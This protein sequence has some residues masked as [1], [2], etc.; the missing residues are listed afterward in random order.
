M[1]RRKFRRLF[2]EVSIELYV[3]SVFASLI[4]DD[5]IESGV[6]IGAIVFRGVLE[7]AV[8]T[9]VRGGEL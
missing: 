7:I 8:C 3:P 5:L 6:Q 1:A 4:D 2:E 9:G